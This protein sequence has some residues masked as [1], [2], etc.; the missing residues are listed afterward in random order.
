M[1]GTHIRDEYLI[2]DGGMLAG[3][4]ANSYKLSRRQLVRLRLKPSHIQ[5]KGSIPCLQPPPPIRAG[6]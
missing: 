5:P 3:T 2:V 4:W 6:F 1:S